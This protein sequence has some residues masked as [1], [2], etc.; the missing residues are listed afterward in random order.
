MLP[1]VNH[2]VSANLGSRTAAWLYDQ[3]TTACILP[4]GMGHLENPKLTTDLSMARDF[5]REHLALKMLEEIRK[6]AR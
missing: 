1:T 5:D 6:I 2:A 3:L 4:P